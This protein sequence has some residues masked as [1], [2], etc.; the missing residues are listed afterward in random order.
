MKAVA[1]HSSTRENSP[2][3][4]ARRDEEL[5]GLQRRRV[6]IVAST[7][8]IGGAEQVAANL[9]RYLD[10]GGFEVTACYLKQ[11]GIVGQQMLS[12]GVDLVPIPGI[13]KARDYFTAFKLMRLIRQRG[14]QLIH[15]HDIHGLIDGAIC[16]TL[17]RGLRHV[18]TFHWGNYPVR[19]PRYARIERAL[20]RVPD[21]L[22][23]VGHV[24]AAAIRDFYGIPAERLRVVWNGIAPPKG[25]ASPEMI[26]AVATAKG[27]VIGSISTLIRQKGLEHLLDAAR[28]MRDAGH[29][30]LLLIAGEGV[31][32]KPLEQKC[33]DLGLDDYVRFLGWVPEASQRALPACDVF[34]QSSLWEAM[35]V[36]VLEAM[37]AGKPIVATSVGENIHVLVD[38]GSGLIVPPADPA[39]LAEALGKLLSDSAL[40]QRLGSE[41]EQRYQEH[42]T[43]E[44]MTRAHQDLYGQL[45]RPPARRTS[46]AR[47]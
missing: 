23:A 31:L 45:V 30:F 2:E 47:T 19:D 42:F 14:I 32:R 20:W 1:T 4:S 41:A 7:L 35:S 3:A 39:A 21:A 40:R 22:V 37:A 10:P 38:G 29:Q 17:M 27:P 26:N 33:R 6:L 24:Q 11:N 34:V 36:V 44:Q 18:H 43:V 15:T 28:L 8:H 13:K 25:A 9:S 5:N 46:G 16:R 12:H